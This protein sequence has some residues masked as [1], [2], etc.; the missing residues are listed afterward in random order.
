M[1]KKGLI[2]TV[3]MVI[4]VA[5]VALAQAAPEDWGP[6][7]GYPTIDAWRQAGRMND[8]ERWGYPYGYSNGGY[9]NGHRYGYPN[10]Y[11]YGYSRPGLTIV[12]PLPPPPPWFRR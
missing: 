3:V 12:I 10:G 4:L 8:M 11:P 7:T 5:A 9:S 6:D 2:I 1:E